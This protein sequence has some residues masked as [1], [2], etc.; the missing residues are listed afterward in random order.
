MATVKYKAEHVSRVMVS[1]V[2]ATTDV[3]ITEEILLVN[4]PVEAAR[5]LRALTEYDRNH[6]EDR[7]ITVLNPDELVH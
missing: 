5:V 3:T 2:S 4:S 1:R 7:G 6:P